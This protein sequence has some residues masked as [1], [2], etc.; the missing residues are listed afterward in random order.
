MASATRTHRLAQE[1]HDKTAQTRS[2][3]FQLHAGYWETA[4]CTDHQKQ[5]HQQLDIMPGIL[6]K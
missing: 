6:S 1:C 2:G 3:S 5:A 4:V